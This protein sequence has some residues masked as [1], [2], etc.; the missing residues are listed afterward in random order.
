M[1]PIMFTLK[2]CYSFSLEEPVE[3]QSMM[4]GMDEGVLDAYLLPLGM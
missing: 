3:A 1:R 2:V 4:N